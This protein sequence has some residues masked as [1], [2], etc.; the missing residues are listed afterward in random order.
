MVEQQHVKAPTRQVRGV[1][2]PTAQPSTAQLVDQ[3]HA[4]NAG[5]GFDGCQLH[6]VGGTDRERPRRCVGRPAARDDRRWGKDW[7]P[8]AR[9]APRPKA[10]ADSVI[11]VHTRTRTGRPRGRPSVLPLRP[12]CNHPFAPPSALSGQSADCRDASIPGPVGSLTSTVMPGTSRR[13]AARTR[14]LSNSSPGGDRECHRHGDRAS[15]I[16]AMAA[17]SAPIRSARA[18][19]SDAR[20]GRLLTRPTHSLSWASKSATDANWRPARNDASRNPSARAASAAGIPLA[21]AVA[22]DATETDEDRRDRPNYRRLRRRCRRRPSRRGR[23]P[24][25]CD[26]RLRRCA[27]GL[28]RRGRRRPALP[29]RD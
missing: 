8:S 17:R 18:A 12:A 10:R 24:R 23:R 6:A 4:V 21:A 22:A 27:G 3:H 7:Q 2:P 19:P 1:V 14:P 11:A 15:A 29:S 28:S 13:S 5:A 26:T 25:R 9:P 16:P 20:R